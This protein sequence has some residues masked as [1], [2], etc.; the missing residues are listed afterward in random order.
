[1]Q[2]PRKCLQCSFKLKKPRR[3]FFLRSTKGEVIYCGRCRLYYSFTAPYTNRFNFYEFK[4]LFNEKDFTIM[5][6]K[7]GSVCI[8]NKPIASFD[9][10]ELEEA[11]KLIA[12]IKENIEFY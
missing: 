9:S 7:S 2:L 5:I 1:M 8:A 3:A 6:F 11:I 4:Y 10:I 12:K